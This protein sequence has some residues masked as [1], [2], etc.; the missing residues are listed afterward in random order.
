MT[1]HP[2][3]K[4][5]PAADPAPADPARAYPAPAHPLL[6]QPLAPQF[7][8]QLAEQQQALLAVLFPNA[9]NRRKLNIKK[10]ANYT[11]IQPENSHDRVP[12]LDRGLQTYLANG[13][14]LAGRSLAA[15]YPVV[16]QLLGEASFAA[17][18]C[19][20]W[21]AHPPVRGDI[22]QWGEQLAAFMQADAQLASEPYL[23][24]VARAEWAMHQ[25]ASL[26]D[27]APQ[28]AS[29]ALLTAPTGQDDPTAL[30]LRLAP[31]TTLLPSRWPVAAIVQAHQTEAAPQAP[32]VPEAQET[33]DGSP[34]PAA[35][36]AQAQAAA[37]LAA[38]GQQIAALQAQ[39]A[40]P[41]GRL[42]HTS[43]VWRSGH[44]PRLRE[45]L[46]GEAAFVAAVLQ[47][48]NLGKALDAAAQQHPVAQ[49]A[50]SS[51]TLHHPAHPEA[52]GQAVF[53]PA[54]FDLT[55][56]LALAVQ[57]GL[58]LGFARERC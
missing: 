19:A 52:Q 56:W 16:Q 32:E 8:Q 42:P 15:S 41:P 46:P 24:D 31:G 57:S 22:A 29:F 2:A 45:A 27:Q 33:P 5:L 14:A 47:G 35:S 37:G 11:H 48:Q 51:A 3:P 18:A 50:S 12:T 55:H 58:L 44:Q 1:Q 40:P 9:Q 49:G 7:T 53:D 26:A 4:H 54:L 20:V 17:L 25:S 34:T 13:E 38:V 36:A 23:P 30:Y 28:P 21:Q 43:L 10:L 6:R 39:P